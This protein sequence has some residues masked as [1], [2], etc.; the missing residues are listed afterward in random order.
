MRR[1][2]VVNAEPWT[3]DAL[4]DALALE[5]FEVVLVR[6]EAEAIRALEGGRTRFADLEVDPARHEVARG[7]RPVDV[8]A[9]EFD[10]LALFLERPG[11]VLSR[12][13]LFN[14]VWGYDFGTNSNALNVHVGRLRRKL[15]AGGEPRLI[16]T[17][18]GVGYVLREP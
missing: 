2:L 5:G 16:H 10:L 6:D 1:V 15:E 14:G 11:E 4:R 13:E 12:A 3:S 17:V 7:G 18:R 8:T 9:T